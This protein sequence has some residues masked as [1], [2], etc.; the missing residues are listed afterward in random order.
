MDKSISVFHPLSGPSFDL[1]HNTWEQQYLNSIRRVVTHGKDVANKRT[2]KVCKTVFH[3]SF[4]VNVADNQVPLPTVRKLGIKKPIAELLGFLR[5]YDNA[6]QFREAGTT[7]W[8]TNA[9]VTQ[10]WVES[11]HRKGE[12]DLGLIYGGVARNWPKHDG[13]T[14]DI[15]TKIY[16]NL[17]N[18]IDD[19][20]E[21]LTFWN[22]GLFEK[23]ALRAC[24]YEHVFCLIDGVLNIESMQRSADSLIGNAINTFQSYVLLRLM[25]Q[26]TGHQAGELVHNCVNY[27]IYDNQ[28]PV[29]FESGMLDREPFPPAQLWINPEIKTLEDVLTWVTVD[30]FRIDGYVSHP[31]VD[32][33]FA[34]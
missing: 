17:R 11:P 19:R 18:G 2:G 28:L 3:Q 31:R 21:I 16:T 1:R 24:M 8:D 9:N 5:G 6:A 30:D 14:I 15:L 25:A 20:G 22:P 13:T 4:H 7:T 32:F 34:E 12:D 10:A 33:P 26:I 29:L 27:H 23:G